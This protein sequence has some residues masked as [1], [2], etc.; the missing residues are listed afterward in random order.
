MS[1]SN[2]Q[3]IKWLASYSTAY[4]APTLDQLF[5]PWGSNLN[6]DPEDS[7]TIEAGFVYDINSSKY[8]LDLV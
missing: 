5:G 2:N 8:N 1:L 3:S 7:Q 4:I 6:L